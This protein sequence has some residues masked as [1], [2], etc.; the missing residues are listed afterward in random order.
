[1]GKTID[2]NGIMGLLPHRYPFLMVDRILDHDEK[3][4]TGVKNVSINE[5]QF[6]GHFP[7]HPIHPGVLIVEGL[8]QCAGCLIFQQVPDREKKVVYFAA[9]DAVKFR[10][11]VFPG[12]TIVYTVDIMRFNGKIAKMKGVAKVDDKVCCEAEMMAIL[13]DKNQAP[14]T[15]AG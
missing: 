15:P 3:Q 10:N 5:P 7:G 12:D 1:M 6:Q 11:P 14:E 2:T 8:A 9:L 13:M 4:I